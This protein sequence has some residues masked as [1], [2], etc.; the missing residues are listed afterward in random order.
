MSNL[1][2]AI[3]VPLHEFSDDNKELL[4]HAI[5]SVPSEYEVRVSCTKGLGKNVNDMKLGKNV[6]VIE[7]DASDFA[8]LVNKAVGGTKWFS[9]LE[10]DDTYTKI[11]FENVARYVEYM[12]DV[13]VFLPLTDLVDFSES[14]FMGYG[15]E[16]PWASSFSN[17]IGHIDNECLQEYFDFYMTGGVFNTEDWE[18]LGGLKASIKLTFWY[19][20]LLR[21]TMKTKKVFVIPKSGYIHCVNRPNSLYAQYR[22]SLTQDETE[23]WFKLAK[24]ECYFKDDR[25]KTYEENKEEKEEEV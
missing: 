17:E 25:H 16:A 2:I 8:S 20:F 18:N 12:P 19:E 4:K 6:K 3:I 9:I 24:Q 10:F 21:A 23:W 13:S 1:D 14:K 22:E 11:W 7:N 15:N 5:E